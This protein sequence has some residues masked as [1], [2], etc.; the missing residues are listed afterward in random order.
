LLPTDDEFREAFLDV[1]GHGREPDTRAVLDVHHETGTDR[2]HTV[3]RARSGNV[4]FSNRVLHYD[5]LTRKPVPDDLLRERL[6]KTARSF[7][8]AC[9]DNRRPPGRSTTRP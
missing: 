4:A 5:P 9:A 7:G 2:A 1:R 8:L 6:L 3:L